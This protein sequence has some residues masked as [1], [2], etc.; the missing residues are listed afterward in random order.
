MA[1][2][3]PIGVETSVIVD[4]ESLHP[5]SIAGQGELFRGTLRKL[6]NVGNLQVA[7]NAWHLASDLFRL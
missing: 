5:L 7:H 4:H 6:I 3:V 1:T 2:T